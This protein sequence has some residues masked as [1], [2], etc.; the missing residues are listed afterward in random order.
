MLGNV[1]Y[2]NDFILFGED[3]DEDLIPTI[4]HLRYET[5]IHIINSDR[6][7][8]MSIWYDAN[9]FLISIQYIH[10]GLKF[11]SS[12]IHSFEYFFFRFDTLVNFL[13]LSS[14][15]ELELELLHFSFVYFDFGRTG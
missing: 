11:P 7:L 8:H 10:F 14:H 13:H 6:L 4:I 1:P 3:F 5:R 9:N 12:F 15:S 2:M